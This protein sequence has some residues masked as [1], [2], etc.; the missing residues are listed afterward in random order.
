MEENKLTANNIEKSIKNNSEKT[1]GTNDPVPTP[2]PL[3][4]PESKPIDPK[5]NNSSKY[6]K[7]DD[8]TAEILTIL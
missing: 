4:S 5:P 1:I 2:K 6:F 8:S 3:P 7:Q